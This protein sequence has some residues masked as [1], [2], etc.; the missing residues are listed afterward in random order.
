MMLNFGCFV[1]AFSSGEI[2]DDV[3]SCVVTFC[4]FLALC[5]YLVLSKCRDGGWFGILYL[6]SVG[7]RAPP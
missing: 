3:E 6:E 4:H 2:L 1:F 5:P 7:P